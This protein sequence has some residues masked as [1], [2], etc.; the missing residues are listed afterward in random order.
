[1]YIFLFEHYSF[2]M[3]AHLL[4][5]IG[6]NTYSGVAWPVCTYCVWP[7]RSPIL[8]GTIESNGPTRTNRVPA[9][10]FG[11]QIGRD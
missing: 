3:W 9:E 7:P 5:H 1:M 6:P 11:L 8:A 2:D 10:P 4:N